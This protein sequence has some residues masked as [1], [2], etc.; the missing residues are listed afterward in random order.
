VKQLFLFIVVGLHA[1]KIKDF[2]SIESLPLQFLPSANLL[3]K[4]QTEVAARFA[5]L[6]SLFVLPLEEERKFLVWALP[7]KST[8]TTRFALDVFNKTL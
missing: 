1:V 8:Y 5:V 2:V 4:F 7:L 6:G 3:S